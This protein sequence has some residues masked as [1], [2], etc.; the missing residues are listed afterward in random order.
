M[1]KNII[2]II[3]III[4]TMIA[5]DYYRSTQQK[6]PIFAVK[7]YHHKDGGTQEYYGVGYKVIKY[8]VI[9]G[10]KD[11]V[12][13]F[14]TMKYENE[15]KHLDQAACEFKM[16][17]NLTKKVTNKDNNIQ[18]LTL[19]KY[20]QSSKTT[21]LYDK[22]RFGDLEEG[23]N[24][25]FTFRTLNPNLENNLEEIFNTS[26]IVS[27]EKVNITDSEIVDDN[28]CFKQKK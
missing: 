28:S 26:E 16:I 15:T 21:I 7:V 27:I 12:F 2:L 20:K 18:T 10:R 23:A 25:S 6:T 19:T 3:L 13:G 22:E 24:Y 1:K 9:S 11:V 5:I 8:N 4:G 17:Y 14:I